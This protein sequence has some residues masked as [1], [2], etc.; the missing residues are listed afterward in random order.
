[1][2]SREAKTLRGPIGSR[3]AF[4]PLW[5]IAILYSNMW[6][7]ATVG[8]GLLAIARR[9]PHGIAPAADLWSA[10]VWGIPPLVPS[11]LPSL[12]PPSPSPLPKS[13][14]FRAHGPE[15]CSFA[16]AMGRDGGRLGSGF[17]LVG[18]RLRWGPVPALVSSGAEACLWPL[19]FT[20]AIHH[21]PD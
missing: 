1:M 16:G 14:R 5:C 3:R 20:S 19:T 17:D 11:L 12:P 4:Y 7:R 15:P 13:S 8:L 10:S 18:S 2:G 9:L 21:R 6:Y